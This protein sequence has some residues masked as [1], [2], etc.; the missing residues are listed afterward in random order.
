MTDWAGK[1]PGVA[2]RIAG[3]LHCVEHSGTFPLPIEISLP[4][5]ERALDIAAILSEHAIAAFGLM[6]ADPAI[7]GAKKVWRWMER[8]R[9]ESFTARDCFQALKG[10]FRRM[11]ELQPAL[12]VLVERAYLAE[13]D[14]KNNKRPGRPSKSY[15]VNTALTEGWK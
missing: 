5:V 4:T 7:E 15:T 9:S 12:E 8:T 10:S 11:S 14:S 1:L 6:G 13:V 2:A 3:L